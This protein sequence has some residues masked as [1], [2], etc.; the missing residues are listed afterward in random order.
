[1]LLS[2]ESIQGGSFVVLPIEEQ[3]LRL[4]NELGFPSSKALGYIDKLPAL[5]SFVPSE[6]L[7]QVAWCAVPA[8]KNVC[9]KY[10]PSLYDDDEEDFEKDSSFGNSY[11]AASRVLHIK[12][13]RIG[14]HDSSYRYDV[15]LHDK[16]SALEYSS[17]MLDRIKM[18]QSSGII[19]IAVKFSHYT[20]K[21]PRRLIKDSFSENE[22]GLGV[23]AVSS[24]ALTHF[25][26]I[27]DLPEMQFACLGDE[28]S[29]PRDG[30]LS[31][32]PSYSFESGRVDLESI[33]SRRSEKGFLYATGFVP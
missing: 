33:V 4:A 26:Q 1:M 13:C 2:K 11:R 6:H 25:D 8:V 15:D 23:L 29:S 5:E 7:S 20:E 19:I 30:D 16:V 14:V 17:F 22:F 9:C 21:S 18:Q 32:F 3:V 12:L 27:K 10:L 28:W 31:I 24:I